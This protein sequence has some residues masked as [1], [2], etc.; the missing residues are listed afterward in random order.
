MQG[1]TVNTRLRNI[2]TFHITPVGSLRF[3]ISLPFHMTV[4]ISKDCFVESKSLC[5]YCSTAFHIFHLMNLSWMA[6]CCIVVVAR[7]GIC[8]VKTRS[9][10]ITQEKTIGGAEFDQR[11]H[12][13][14]EKNC[15]LLHYPHSVPH[16]CQLKIS[17]DV[18]I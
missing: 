11:L 17:G 1:D 18:R 12:F 15:I 9:R 7:G 16:I 5:S 3:L 4:D 6:P 10:I 2:N 8:W 13:T 14:N